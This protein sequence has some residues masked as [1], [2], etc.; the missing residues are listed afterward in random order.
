[1]YNNLFHPNKVKN[2][3]NYINKYNIT[4]GKL[5]INVIKHFF[6]QGTSFDLVIKKKIKVF[7]DMI[8]V[9]YINTSNKV[10]TAKFCTK[11]TSLEVS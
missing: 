7:M 3:N 8:V 9:S 10:A 2:Y 4:Q 6:H 1:M 11:L 5:E